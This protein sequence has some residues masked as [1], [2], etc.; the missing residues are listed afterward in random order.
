MNAERI[1]DFR[2]AALWA[3][4]AGGA[5][6]FGWGVFMVSARLLYGTIG[7]G[8]LRMAW[9]TWMDIGQTHGVF[10]GLPLMGIGLVLI[11]FGRPLARWIVVPPGTG[12][13]ACGYPASGDAEPGCAEPGC[14]ECGYR[15]AGGAA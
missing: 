6:L 11:V 4:R 13:P 10:R 3:I 8:Q 9:T 14:T 7:T 15:S 1:H 2:A 12:C 5:S